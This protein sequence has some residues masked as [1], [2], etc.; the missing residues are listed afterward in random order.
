MD[1]LRGLRTDTWHRLEQRQRIDVTAQPVELRPASGIEHL[2]D[3]PRETRAHAGK[4]LE[5][6]AAALGIEVADAAREPFDTVGRLAIGAD[7]KRVRLL[8]LE[9]IGGLAQRL[10]NA[11]IV[12]EADAVGGRHSSRFQRSARAFCAST[13]PTG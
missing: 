8:R 2:R 7:A 13:A 1:A 3:R 5:T 10:G 4:G 11:L 12:G 9:E 6:D